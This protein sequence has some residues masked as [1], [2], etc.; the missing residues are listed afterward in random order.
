MQENKITVHI[1]Y[2]LTNQT[3]KS[4]QFTNKH[5]CENSLHQL[6]PNQ[7]QRS[8]QHLTPSHISEYKVTTIDTINTDHTFAENKT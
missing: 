6:A 3:L 1:R 5:I 4:T 7:I 8:Y 2:T